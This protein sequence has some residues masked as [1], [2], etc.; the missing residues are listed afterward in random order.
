MLPSL[1]SGIEDTIETISQQKMKLTKIIFG[2]ERNSTIS[3]ITVSFWCFRTYRDFDQIQKMIR[4]LRFD[5]LLYTFVIF[6][7]NYMN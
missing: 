6:D 4:G 2:P 7:N 3:V 1:S 5:E